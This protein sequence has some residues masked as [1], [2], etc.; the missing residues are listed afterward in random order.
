[1][2]VQIQILIAVGAYICVVFVPNRLADVVAGCLIVLWLPG[3]AWLEV[4]L[5]RLASRWWER[6]AVTVLLSAAISILIGLALNLV[7]AGLDRRTEFT[8]WLSVT[9]AGLILSGFLSSR[10]RDTP[11][12]EASEARDRSSRSS[13][14]SSISSAVDERK[15][16]LASGLATLALFAGAVGSSLISSH[17][18]SSVSSITTHSAI[19][20][21]GHGVGISATSTDALSKLYT[22]VLFGGASSRQVL[23]ADIRTRKP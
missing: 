22:I 4:L 8:G 18:A 17:H 7:P 20:V 12:D 15:W 5:D 19:P 1:M 14:L 10:R 23:R 3:A 6:L 2:R 11:S 16:A 21:A 13:V 9:A